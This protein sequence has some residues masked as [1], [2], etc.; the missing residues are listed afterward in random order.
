MLFLLIVSRLLTLYVI[1]LNIER[2]IS[3][4]ALYLCDVSK[5]V[6]DV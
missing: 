4:K 1:A 3:K 6:K 2:N 5:T